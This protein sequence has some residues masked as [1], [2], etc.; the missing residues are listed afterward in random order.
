MTKIAV[1]SDL[2]GNMPAIEKVIADLALRQIKRVFC[3]GDL[4]SGPLWPK[5]TIEFLMRQDWTYIR[6]NHDRWLVERVPERLGPSDVYAR[7]FLNANELDWLASL[8]ATREIDGTFLLCHGSPAKDTTYLLETIEHGGIR[9]SSA[10]DIAAKAGETRLPILLCGHSHTPRAVNLP[11][12]LTILNPGSVGVPAYEDDS[13]GYFVVE[14][15]SPHARY[16]ILEECEGKWKAEIVL[17]PYDHQKAVEQA[18]R[19]NRP[20][21]VIALGTG[22]MK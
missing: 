10:K 7:Q 20:D 18:R 16:A 1:L 21:Y 15:G 4:V 9:L 12:G 19:N 5:E 3:L 14:N 6:G 2:H 11:G 8:P 13:D 22:F 17:L